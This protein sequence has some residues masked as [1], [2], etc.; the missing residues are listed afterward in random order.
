MNF[1]FQLN[2]N[3]YNEAILEDSRKTS[4]SE[5]RIIHKWAL[6][7]GVFFLLMGIISQEKGFL[8]V[9]ISLL[10]LPIFCQLFVRTGAEEVYETYDMESGTIVD[11][12]RKMPIVANSSNY[13]EPMTVEVIE[14]GL[15]INTPSWQGIFKWKTFKFFT[16]SSNSLVIYPVPSL[17][18]TSYS[19]F[20][21]PKRAFSGEE[22]LSD[23]RE[24]LHKNI[25][26]TAKII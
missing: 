22:Q 6:L 11:Q 4:E 1:E 13:G 20:I 24:L 21:I 25:G 8:V 3:D 9:G 23:F 18:P 12:D 16:E 10:S 19:N 14:E 5:S 17:Y 26:K 7:I 15:V 2:S